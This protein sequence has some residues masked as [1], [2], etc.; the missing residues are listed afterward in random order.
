M[1]GMGIAPSASDDIM[2]NHQFQE[3][4]L[5]I[6]TFQDAIRIVPRLARDMPYRNGYETARIG[7]MYQLFISYLKGIRMNLTKLM[8]Y[9]QGENPFGMEIK[10]ESRLFDVGHLWLEWFEKQLARN[11]MWALSGI[12]REDNALLYLQG[13]YVGYYI[14]AKRDFADY[15]GLDGNKAA[16]FAEDSVWANPKRSREWWRKWSFPNIRPFWPPSEKSTGCGVELPLSQA[17]DLCVQHTPITESDLLS[18]FPSLDEV[19]NW[20]SKNCKIPLPQYFVGDL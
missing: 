19:L 6:L 18:F 2:N 15:F 7:L 4:P 9:A 14:F 8:Q 3:E 1:D 5:R 20:T 17:R 13:T 10:Y 16:F 12:W 11:L